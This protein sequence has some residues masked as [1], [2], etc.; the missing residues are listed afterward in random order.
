MGLGGH[1]RSEAQLPDDRTWRLLPGPGRLRRRR[2]AV[3]FEHA[4]RASSP[5]KA[6]SLRF[7]F[8]QRRRVHRYRCS[9]WHLRTDDSLERVRIVRALLDAKPAYVALRFVRGLLALP[10]VLTTPCVPPD[11][12][13]AARRRWAGLVAAI[14]TA[15][16]GWS[17][18]VRS[19]T[20][21]RTSTWASTCCTPS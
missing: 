17:V 8:A 21:R 18:A 13:R 16:T 10:T 11:F 19:G 1:L 20:S 5:S 15:N 4:R 6:T 3:C 14:S 12:K 9:S 2:F 7:G